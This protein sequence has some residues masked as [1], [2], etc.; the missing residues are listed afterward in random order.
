MGCSACARIRPTQL[1]SWH[2]RARAQ[3]PD[4]QLPQ[5]ASQPG[6]AFSTQRPS[7]T[8]GT[9]P[10]PVI[11]PGG[12]TGWNAPAKA[13]AGLRRPRT[14]PWG[15]N[16]SVSGWAWRPTLAGEGGFNV[17]MGHAPMADRPRAEWR[18]HVQLGNNPAELRALQP[19]GWKTDTRNDWFASTWIDM[20]RRSLYFRPSANGFPACAPAPTSAWTWASRSRR[21]ASSAWGACPVPGAGDVMLPD[22]TL[23]PAHHDRIH[24]GGFQARLVFDQ[25][26]DP[27]LPRRAG[28]SRPCGN[29][30]CAG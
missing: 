28:G 10:R 22:G 21:S 30:G 14:S 12:I 4:S 9:S 26:D 23:D 18:N 7:W 13:K 15:P 17:R 1:A 2:R 25:L 19:L 29:A 20:E 16:Y 8:P 6:Q 27:W 5:F 24:E 11:T 3:P